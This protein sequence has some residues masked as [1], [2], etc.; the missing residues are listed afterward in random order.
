MDMELIELFSSIDIWLEEFL[1][2][3]GVLAP[4][5]CCVLIFLEGILAFLPLVVFVTVNVLSLTTLLGEFWGSVVAILLSWIFSTLGSFTTFTLVRK[6][7][8]KPF[9]K[10]IAK[11][12]KVS[13][14]MN[15]IDKLKYSHL[16]LITSIPFSPSF[17]INL[18]AGLSNVNSKKYFCAL[19]IGKFV[20]MIFLG[21]VGVSLVE[22]LTNPMALIKVVIIIVIGYVVSVIVNKKFDLDERFE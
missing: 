12:P 7:F 11:H 1:M 18:G 9:R 15:M 4:L 14:F 22:C 17:F 5:L 6:V 16:V 2:N 19:M 21:Y 10:R 8:N 13:K 3:A 20:E